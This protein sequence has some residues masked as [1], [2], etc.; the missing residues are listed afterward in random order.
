MEYLLKGDAQL[1]KK[2]LQNNFLVLFLF[3]KS[4]LYVCKRKGQFSG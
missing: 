3:K 2:Y 4:E 1:T